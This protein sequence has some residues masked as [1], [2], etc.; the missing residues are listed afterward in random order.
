[1]TFQNL[2]YF[3]EAAKDLNFSKTAERLFVSQQS[4]SKHISKLEEHYRVCLFERKPNLRLTREGQLIAAKAA[5]IFTIENNLREEL[6]Q[7][8]LQKSVT[9][10]VKCNLTKASAFFPDILMRFVEQY[11]EAQ[12]TCEESRTNE[13]GDMRIQDD[14]INHNIHFY[15][16]EQIP[17][18]DP[19]IIKTLLLRD[20][21]LF[22]LSRQKYHDVFMRTAPFWQE[23]PRAYPS[24]ISATSRF[25]RRRTS[26]C[27]ARMHSFF[28]G[29]AG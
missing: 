1:M 21:N 8:K 10:S 7:L 2:Y 12:I 23:R 14:L 28:T 9:I 13:L 6:T 18:D 27:P 22:A 3:L 16:G 11:P 25:F 24:A 15:I 4:I 17:S 26:T 29:P 19:A 20:R 5:L